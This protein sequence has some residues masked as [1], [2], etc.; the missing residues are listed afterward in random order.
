M[1][2]T[3]YKYSYSGADIVNSVWFQTANGIS[4]ASKLDSLGTISFSIHEAKASVRTLGNKGIKG[5]TSGIRT[6]AGSMIFNIINEHPLSPLFDLYSTI[7]KD[8]GVWTY[9]RDYLRS[10]YINEENNGQLPTTL[11]PFNLHIL[12]ITELEQTYDGYL[13]KI[14]SHQYNEKGTLLV[15]VNEAILY[16]IEFI[17]DNTVFSI[18]NILT[19]NTFSFIAQD[20]QVLSKRKINVPFSSTVEDLTKLSFFN[21]RD[22][23][24]NNQN[25]DKISNLKGVERI[26]KIDGETYTIKGST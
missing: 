6:C 15:E 26:D 4:A 14:P 7:Y 20:I 9:S 25:I 12:A 16:G 8:I 19:E 18:N 3:G 1:E 10:N 21:S 17:D 24:W 2:T 13:S 11:P 22:E 23:S 5:N